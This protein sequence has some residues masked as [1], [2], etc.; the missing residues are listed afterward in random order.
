ML[1]RNGHATCDSIEEPGSRIRRLGDADIW[2]HPE[3]IGA[4][5]RRRTLR[6]KPYFFG[7]GSKQGPFM[8]KRNSHVLVDDI[9]CDAP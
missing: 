2:K 5:D 1:L 7:Q 9:L 6:R 3:F 8:L 4:H